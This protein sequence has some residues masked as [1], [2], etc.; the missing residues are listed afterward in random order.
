MSIPN[1]TNITATLI[2]KELFE[3][4]ISEKEII[5]VDFST[6]DYIPH[7]KSFYS[8]TDT[9]FLTLENNQVA[10]YNATTQKWLNKDL[11]ETIVDV[12]FVQNETPTEIIPTQFRT[13]NIFKSTS[14]QVYLNGLKFHSS[15][16]TIDSNKTFTIPISKLATDSIECSYIK[17]ATS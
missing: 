2:E 8:L 14:L 10:V 7:R 5:T 3:V 17:T 12:L 13:V 15:E 11:E 6:I 9:E 4:E 16:I 1:Q